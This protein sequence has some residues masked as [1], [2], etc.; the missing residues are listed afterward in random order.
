MH[1]SINYIIAC[2]FSLFP[3]QSHSGN[4]YIFRHLDLI[5]G[6]S[7]NQIRSISQAPDGRIGIKTASIFNMYN[8]ATFEHFYHDTKKEYRWHH[9]LPPRECYDN[10][11]RVWIKEANY[12][13]LLDLH[14][15]Q[16]IYTIEEE[17]KT[18]GVREKLVDLFIDNAKNYWFVTEDGT[19][20]FYDM[21]KREWKLITEGKSAFSVQYGIPKEMCQ[22]KNLCWIV[23]SSGLIRCWDYASGEFV[24]QDTTFLNAI[25]PNTNRIYI[26]PSEAGDIWLMYNDGVF[27]YN[28]TDKHWTTVARITGLSNFFTCMDLDKDGNVWVGTSRSGLRYINARTLK[29]E[30][31]KGL[32][33]DNGILN[34]DIHSVFVDDN[35]GLWVGTL[36]QGVCYFHPNR[37]KFQLFHTV[38]AESKIT[39]EV[40][41]CFLEED[42]GNILIGTSHGLFRFYPDTKKIEKL[43]ENQISTLC[44]SLYHDSKKR[45]WIGTFLNGF[46]CIDGDKLKNYDVSNSLNQNTGRAIYED[47]SGRYWV[48]V[49]NDGVGRLDLENGKITPLHEKHPQ[50]RAYYICYNFFPGKDNQLAIVG[51]NG[52]YYYNTE[53][54]SVWIPE[55]HEPDSPKFQDVGIKYYCLLKDSRSLE[56]FGT[57][58]GIRIWD[59]ENKKRYVIDV[60]EGLPNNNVMAILEDSTGVVWISTAIGITKIN[61]SKTNREYAFSLVDF[62]TSDGLQSG[63]F[64][65]RSALKAKNGDFYFG[66]FHGFNCFNPQKI[67]YNETHRKPVFTTFKLFN[68][69][70]KENTLY[71]GRAIL[72]R[73]LNQTKEIRLRYNENYFSLEFA[74][75]NYVNPSQTYFK[76]KLENLDRNWTEILAHGQGSVTYTGLQPGDYCFKVYA[77]NNDKY[78]SDEY[79]EIKIVIAPPVWATIYAFIFYTLSIGVIAYCTIRYLI[80]RNRLKTKRQMRLEAEKQKQELDQLKFRFF[81]NISHEFRTPLSLILSPLEALI[82]R[83]KDDT[84]KQKLSKIHK[85]AQDLLSLVNQLLDFRKLEMKGEELHLNYGDMVEFIDVYYQTFREI[86]D[87]EQKDIS[88]LVKTEHLYLFFDKDKLHKILNNLLSNAFKYTMKGG[89]ITLSL[90]KTVMN[91]REYAMIKIADTGTG[92]PEEKIAKI[93]DRFYQ[94][95]NQEN[96]KQGSGI[97][98]HLVKEYVNLH[99]GMILAESVLNKGSVFTV[100][101]PTDLKKENLEPEAIPVNAKDENNRMEI[102]EPAKSANRKTILIVEDNDEFR[103]FLLEQLE[104][105]F[106][107]IEAANGE[108]GEQQALKES[109]DLIIT[110]IM[111]PKVDGVELCSRIKNNIQTSHIPLILLTA[112]TSDESKLIGYEAGADEYISKPFNFDILLLR[113]QKLIK[114]QEDRKEKFRNSIEINPNTITITSLDEVLIQKALAH[115]EANMSNTDYSIDDLSNGIGLSRANLYRKI[116]SIAG[117]TP[118]GF[119]RSIRLKR[120]AQLLYD[121]KLNISEIADMVGFGTIKYFNIHFKEE[122]GVTPTQYRQN[123]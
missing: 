95:E 14:T 100:L 119:I 101:I 2:L 106:L 21:E 88:L 33:L 91:N 1:R 24:G 112:R 53:T 86:A 13:L 46:Y 41:R 6:L 104:P 81:T 38:K 48:S 27:F 92:I 73:S 74:G 115:I 87:N 96:S 120:A 57:E 114:Q 37:Q 123:N 3:I 98:L 54:D 52:I 103:Q 76:Y 71:G 118:A 80:K 40:V 42:N 31:V 23:Y 56:W 69:I 79:A 111:M 59:H 15:N 45:I 55:L 121:T 117:E 44:L 110:D 83:E 11:G 116:Q 66:G 20:S 97:G 78:W 8:G 51:E 70:I 109:P 122:F 7:D 29:V 39:N 58:R 34:N 12:L 94:L 113:I 60:E 28:R 102:K 64:Y 32:Q 90:E 62:N 16:Y 19:F 65:D 99:N 108:E 75:L 82:K 43:F 50:S 77:A 26:H 4:E 61:V 10:K 36:L 47:T 9:Y 35:N 18:L 85:N 22:Y 107:I 17:L 67:S 5:D 72:Q 30:T 63:K 49:N 89:Q 25:T 68:S 84:L 93:F 105:E